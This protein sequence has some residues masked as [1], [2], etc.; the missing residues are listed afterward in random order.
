M[1]NIQRNV[2]DYFYQRTDS[3]NMGQAL[4]FRTHHQLKVAIM[5]RLRDH[6]HSGVLRVRSMET[7]EEMRD[8]T[9]D[10]DSI[11]AEGSAHDDRPLA[12]ALACRQ[13]EE[14]PRRK[15][16]A[17][18]RTREAEIAKRRMSTVDMVKAFNTNQFGT[19]LA[20]RDAVRRAQ[21]AA[22]QGGRWGRRR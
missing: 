12:L 21:L 7:I 17:S 9:R 16:M 20:G 10:G 18:R 4:M 2:R 3:I 19:F 8:I 11:G 22:L 15:L 1:V 5:E 13:W 14:G 6:T